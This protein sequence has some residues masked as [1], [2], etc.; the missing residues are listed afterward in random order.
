MLNSLHH[1][2]CSQTSICRPTMMMMKL[3]KKNCETCKAFGEAGKRRSSAPFGLF[4]PGR[5]V[6]LFLSS[7]ASSSSSLSSTSASSSP[8]SSLP[9]SAPWL[10]PSASASASASLPCSEPQPHLTHVHPATCEL[11]QSNA[12]ALLIISIS[13]MIWFLLFGMSDKSQCTQSENVLIG[14]YARVIKKIYCHLFLCK[15]LAA[16][17]IRMRGQPKCASGEAWM[18]Q[19]YPDY[20]LQ[21]Q[22]NCSARHLPTYLPNVVHFSDRLSRF[23]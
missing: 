20:Q 4:P 21:P 6:M 12:N 23:F 2:S 10:L 18:A 15:A 11:K 9:E 8:S 16:V 19:N 1:L 22:A 3:I 7:S 5:S 13:A 17:C 14:L